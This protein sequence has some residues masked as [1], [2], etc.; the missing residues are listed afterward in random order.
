MA[1]QGHSNEN[2]PTAS[3]SGRPEHEESSNVKDKNTRSCTSFPPTST[4]TEEN[5]EVNSDACEVESLPG[6]K[7]RSPQGILRNCNTCPEL[8]LRELKVK[9]I[10]ENDVQNMRLESSQ[11]SMT[12]EIKRC[13]L[14]GLGLELVLIR[15][16]L[17]PRLG[18]SIWL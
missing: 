6:L 4:S 17:G 11:P 18:T 10:D 9:D 12:D 14:L 15:L 13:V 16:G 8:S 1:S 3:G 7:N 2:C 5:T